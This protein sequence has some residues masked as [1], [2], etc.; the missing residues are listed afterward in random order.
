[1]NIGVLGGTFDPIHLGHLEVA[2]T[3]RSRLG[4]EEVIFLPAGQPWLKESHDISDKEHRIQMVRLAIAGKPRFKLST[5]ET[6]RAGASYSSETM[7]ELKSRIGSQDELFFILGC[8]TLEEISRWHEPSRLTE[9][10]RLV[11]VPRPGCY[12]PDMDR[13]EQAVPGLSRR[14]ILLDEPRIDVSSTEIRER[15]ARGMSISH[16]V[17]GVVADYIKQQGLYLKT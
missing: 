14:V 2:D 11:V 15:A 13:L 12:P 7:A 4:L 3:V 5:L 9:S 17:P 10:C 1:M 8:D 6:E 16:L